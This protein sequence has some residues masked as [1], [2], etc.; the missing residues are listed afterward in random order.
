MKVIL[1]GYMGSGKSTI[2]RDLSKALQ[3]EFIDLDSFIEEQENSSISH[4]F[5][6][7]GEIYFRKMESL[8]LKKLLDEKENVVLSLGGGTP[9]YGMN[10]KIIN[11]SDNTISF[12]LKASIDT[13]SNRLLAEKNQRPLISHLENISELQEFIGKHL[14]ERSFYYNRAQRIINVDRKLSK[15]MV[16]EMVFNLLQ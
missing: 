1:M 11:D 13:L 10:L 15:D 9:C 14:F 2:G 16:E 6:T 12:Y 5:E 7:K 3:Y 4:I 8:Y